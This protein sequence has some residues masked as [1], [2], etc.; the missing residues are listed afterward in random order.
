M[1]SSI[2]IIPQNCIDN[3]LHLHPTLDLYALSL[4][5]T[6]LNLDPHVS[7]IFSG[8]TSPFLSTEFWSQACFAK[9]LQGA[10]NK[11]HLEE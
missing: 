8:G 3:I 11:M 6:F 1:F 5:S 7:V 2:V 9:T 4:E 10:T